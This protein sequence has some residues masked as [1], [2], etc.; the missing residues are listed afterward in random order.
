MKEFSLM[1][2]GVYAPE[3]GKKEDTETFYK[4]LQKQINQH[5]KLD[6]LIVCG[7]LNIRIGNNQY[8][9]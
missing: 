1:I 6:A 7:N 2:I 3:D 9:T 8:L 5:N 4:D